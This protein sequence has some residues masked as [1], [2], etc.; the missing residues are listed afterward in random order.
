MIANLFNEMFYQPIYNGLVFLIDVI[1]GA[2]VGIAIIIL[3]ITVKFIILPFS[4]KS[5]KSQA[6]MRAIEPEIKEIK[7]KHSKDKQEQSRKVMELYKKHGVNPFTGC[8]LVLVQLPIMLALYW[9]FFKGLGDINTDII[10]SFVSIPEHVNMEFLGLINMLGK[11]LVL[12]VLAGI[13]QYYQM[14]LSMPPI[15]AQKNDLNKKKDISFKDEFVK[16]MNTQMRYV[17][18]VFIFFIAYTISSAVA[19]YW[20]VNN[21]FSIIHELIVRRK[22][23]EIMGN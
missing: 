20:V 8:V 14:R 18:P 2:D 21:L 22:A 15:Q 9:V 19:L 4:H 7:E 23:K 10:Y 3:T 12:A 17:L 16:N 13:T 1:P 11:S 6:K 5:V